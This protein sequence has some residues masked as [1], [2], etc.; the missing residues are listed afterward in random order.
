MIV[1]QAQQ[2]QVTQLGTK[3]ISILKFEKWNKAIF[4]FFRIR[5]LYSDFM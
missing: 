1:G 3:K 2:E 4:Q 5:N